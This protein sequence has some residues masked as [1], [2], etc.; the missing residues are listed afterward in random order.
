MKKSIKIFALTEDLN[1]QQ[2]IIQKYK[3]EDTEICFFTDE[4][5]VIALMQF[6]P[7]VIIINYELDQIMYNQYSSKAQKAA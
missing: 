3:R 1:I 4:F 6:Q 2:K 5:S 7:D